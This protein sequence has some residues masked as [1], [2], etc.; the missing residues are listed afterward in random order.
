MNIYL[1]PEPVQLKIFVMH[2]PD[3][4]VEGKTAAESISSRLLR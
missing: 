4:F 2:I 1:A 3:E